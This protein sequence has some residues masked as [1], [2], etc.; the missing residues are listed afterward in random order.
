M[1]GC[2]VPFAASASGLDLPPAL[3]VSG[4]YNPTRHLW[5]LA[6]DHA[7][8]S[9]PPAPDPSHW[10]VSRGGTPLANPTVTPT[11]G[12]VDLELPA[13]NGLEDSFTYTGPPP[14]WRD[15]RGILMLAW[16]DFGP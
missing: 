3:P 9:P 8:T 4:A 13:Y 12:G 10:Q 6:F 7:L 14:N 11:V 2:P 15:D 5:H 1:G 16:Y